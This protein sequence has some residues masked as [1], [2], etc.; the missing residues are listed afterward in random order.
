MNRYQ[1]KTP[2]LFCIVAIFLLASLTLAGCSSTPTTKATH[3][4][5]PTA[6]SSQTT[7]APTSTQMSTLTP[8]IVDPGWQVVFQKNGSQEQN[9]VTT[10]STLGVFTA[11]KPLRIWI[12]CL[13]TGSVE[14]NLGHNIDIMVSCTNN[15]PILDGNTPT[16]IT[17][18]TNYTVITT[19][20]GVVQWEMLIE[21]QN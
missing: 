18:S 19:I 1:Y 5:T 9:G 17:A 14:I 21:A 6:S 10:Q 20:T 13:G 12:A 8:L 7:V 11:A 3:L 16:P 2:T 15:T 4:M